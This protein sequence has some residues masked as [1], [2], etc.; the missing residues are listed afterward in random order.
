MARADCPVCQGSG[1]KIVERTTQGAQALAAAESARPGA[2]AGEPKMVW[3]IPCDCT[4]GDR[5]D[6]VLARA[7]V[8]ERY[9]HCDFENYETDN[10]I[11]NVAREQLAAW[12]RSLTQA[13]L[14]VRRFA[15][16]FPVGNEHGLLL[17][18]PCGVGKT[19][20][21]VAALKEIVLRGHTGLFYDYRELLKE[22][23]DSYTT[24]SESTEMGVLEPVLKAEILVLDDTGSSKPSLWALETAGH[25]LNTRYNEKRVTLLTTNFLDSEAGEN[26]AAPAPSRRGAGL[27]APAIEDSLTD[28]VGKRIRSRLYEMCRTVEIFAPDYRK[29]IRNLSR[30]R[31]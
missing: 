19:H 11:E 28:R 21:A 17:M 29:E 13:K 22:I 2:A 4:A 18:G 5:T 8:P 31:A 23:Q 6:R 1:W 9:R 20:L 15:D 24:E 3:A 26:A 10:E 12:N 27:R 14:V 7:R 16:E 25:V 30:G